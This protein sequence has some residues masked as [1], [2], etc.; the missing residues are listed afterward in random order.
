MTRGDSRQTHQVTQQVLECL[1]RSRVYKVLSQALGPP[2]LAILKG[3]VRSEA[4]EDLARMTRLLSPEIIKVTLEF[5]Q[6][7]ENAQLDAE[8]IRRDYEHSF[9]E[10][11]SA[12]IPL[13]ETEYTSPHVFAKT[14]MLA[15]IAG[16]Y[17]AFGMRSNHRLGERPDHASAE[18]EFMHLLTLMEANASSEENEY[19]VEVCLDARRKFVEDH[20]GRWLLPMGTAVA[21]V[22]DTNLYKTLGKLITVFL[23]DEKRRLGA[24]PQEVSIRVQRPPFDQKEDRVCGL[25]EASHR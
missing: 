15:D 22:A 18:L 2:D 14:Q 7:L 24:K 19:R 25:G 11:G 8:N 16:F 17:R 12:H 9:S 6:T 23:E 4:V 1:A 21:Q 20:I 3:S 10:S 13:Y 5:A